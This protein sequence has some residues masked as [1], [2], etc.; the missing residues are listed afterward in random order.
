MFTEFRF[1]THT[2]HASGKLLSVIQ[3]GVM[4]RVRVAFSLLFPVKHL[5]PCLER[6]EHFDLRRVISTKKKLN[7]MTIK[8]KR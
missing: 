2:K 5:T 4:R 6:V 8:S 3:R 7:L 1:G